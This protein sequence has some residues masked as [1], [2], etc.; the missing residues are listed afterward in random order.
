MIRRDAAAGVAEVRRSR[1]YHAL[2]G[3]GL[4][5]YGLLH[6][7]LAW[8]AIQIVLW[9]RGE[10]S[11]EGALSELRRQPLGDVLLW[12][13]AIGL[14]TLT[15]WQAV[16]AT[17]GRDQPNRD[18]RLRR[19]LMSAGRAILYLALAA[20]AIGV[21]T[22][23]ATGSSDGE[24]TFTATLMSVPFGQ[25]LVAVVG[26]V[27]IGIGIAQIIKGGKQNFTEDLDRGAPPAVRRLGTVGYCAKGIALMI[28]GGLFV[29]AAISY[30]PD[31]AGGMDAALG[32]VRD[33]PF[34]A[35]LLTIMA[36]GIACFGVYCFFWARMARY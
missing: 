27:V 4:V 5:S 12:I 10:A 16:E 3:V 35:V 30:D 11:S 28:I 6:L 25:V 14:L 36:V 13:M 33:Q 7:V 22:G 26:V 23:S 8:I 15:L 1:P 32:T 19:R 29:W 17:I 21:A 9:K 31:K 18:S 2:I 24:E 34:G 20:L